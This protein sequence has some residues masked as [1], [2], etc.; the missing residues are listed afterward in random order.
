MLTIEACGIGHKVYWNGIVRFTCTEDEDEQKAPQIVRIADIDTFDT[1]Q[2]LLVDS[3]TTV[4][5][6][7][8]TLED[9]RPLTSEE[10]A[11]LEDEDANATF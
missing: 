8:V 9:V 1:Y 4:D 7:W 6:W 10:Q 3:L 11:D 2:P 5:C